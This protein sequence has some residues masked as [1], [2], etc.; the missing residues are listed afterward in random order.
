MSSF[1]CESPE[2][3]EEKELMKSLVDQQEQAHESSSFLLQ[4]L[5][6]RTSLSPSS[7]E[8]MPPLP[9]PPSFSTLNGIEEE[10][11]EAYESAQKS[12]PPEVTT[13]D[14]GEESCTLTTG[15]LASLESHRPP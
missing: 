15:Q 7:S 9:Q 6:L 4:N 3:K 5:H 13:H 1:E 10:T 8:V 12:Y 11:G 14:E 2:G